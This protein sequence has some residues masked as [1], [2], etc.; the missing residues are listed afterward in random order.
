MQL[1]VVGDVESA[2]SVADGFQGAGIVLLD[3][4]W[5]LAGSRIAVTAVVLRDWFV[6]D[7]DHP[8]GG[9]RGVVVNTVRHPGEPLLRTAKVVVVEESSRLVVLARKNVFL[10]TARSTVKIDNDVDTKVS[11]L[12][13]NSV[14]IRQ[15]AVAVGKGLTSLIH[16]IRVG[17]VSNWDSDGVE[18]DV[19]D[20]LNSIGVDPGFPV[21]FK[22]LVS[23][24]TV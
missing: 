8:H 17:P 9:V 14:E 18:S 24:L 16:D 15:H 5:V 22:S 20:R 4:S 10:L 6:E 12:L 21:L 3:Q 2:L 13:D 1:L 11:S 19:V 23:C 7:L